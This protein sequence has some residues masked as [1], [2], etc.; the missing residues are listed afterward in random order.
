VSA[1]RGRSLFWTIAGVLLLAVVLGTLVQWIMA[2]AVLR[3]LE[4]REFQSRAE[5]MAASAAS[6]LTETPS[7]PSGDALEELLARHRARFGP[8]PPLLIFRAADGEIAPYRLRFLATT[9]DSMAGGALATP[10]PGG[11]RP[12]MPPGPPER[13]EPPDR[14]EFPRGPG[15]GAP[16]LTV[17]A[18]RPVLHSARRVGD[19]LVLRPVRPTRGPW[20]PE[21]RWSLLFLP[22]A[23]VAS[24]VAGLVIVRLLV[25]RLRAVEVLAARV[26]EGD[27]SVRIGDRSGDEIGRIAD[28]LDTMTERIAAAQAS[29]QRVDAQRRQLFADITHELATP[30]TSIRGYAETLL[31]PGVPKSDDERARYVRGVLEESRRLDRLIRDLF[32]LARLEAGAA[33]LTRE[34]LDWS[35]LCANTVERFQPRFRNAGLT[36]GWT[37]PASAAWIDADGHRM[38]QVLENLLGNALRYVPSGGTVELS[39]ARVAASPMRWRLEASDDGPGLPP[40]ELPRVF[41]RFYRASGGRPASDNGGSGLGLAIVREIVERHGGTVSARARAPHGL[42]MVVEMPVAEY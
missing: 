13:L 9:L 26:A 21:A 40:E 6:E 33:P 29:L 37:A 12:G 3:P 20:P 16:K 41:Q 32:E 14:G 27:L 24:A 8:R 1:A 19:V 31:D 35:A 22:I 36:L 5:L 2:V 39:L 42:V 38:E 10:P 25:R 17:V 15:P 23:V 7:F 11:E 18:H 30:L 34:P 4:E 28:R